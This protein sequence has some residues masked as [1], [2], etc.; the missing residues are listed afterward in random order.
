MGEVDPE[1]RNEADKALRKNVDSN[2]LQD[3]VKTN[4][5]ANGE[6]KG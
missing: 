3:D 2:K 1:Y 4:S 6:R 5:D